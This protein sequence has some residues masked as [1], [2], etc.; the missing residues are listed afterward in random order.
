MSTPKIGH[1]RCFIP[2]SLQ[3][4]HNMPTSRTS[5]IT[6]KEW[7]VRKRRI[8]ELYVGDQLQLTGPDGV[9]ETMA[10]EGFTATK[11]Q[12]VYQFH[13]WQVRKNMKRHQWEEVIR[14]R[15]R[16]EAPTPI[17][18]GG[19]VLSEARTEKALRRY[20]HGMPQAEGSVS[21]NDGG[22]APGSTRSLT[23]TEDRRTAADNLV[24][25][26]EIP[27]AMSHHTTGNM[28]THLG[29]DFINSSQAGLMLEQANET[30]D[31]LLHENHNTVNFDMDIFNQPDFNFNTPV[32]LDDHFS[33]SQ[34][35][36]LGDDVLP[37]QG[38]FPG[39]L[40]GRTV[41]G[42][43]LRNHE[44][45]SPQL[46]ATIF[47]TYMEPTLD[48]YCSS[49]IVS[50]SPTTTC[51]LYRRFLKG[52]RWTPPSAAITAKL[53]KDIYKAARTSSS[54]G[55][56]LNMYHLVNNF[57]SDIKS[58]G[59]RHSP[60]SVT[61]AVK[62]LLSTETFFG[63]AFTFPEEVA[64]SVATEARLYS[65][66]ITSV[67]NG[68]TDLKGI[69]A[70]GVLKFLNRHQTTTISMISFLSSN[71]SPVAKSLAENILPIALE[72]DDVNTV[73][74]LL[75]HSGCVDANDAVSVY[76][77]E[78]YTPLQIAARSQSHSSVTL[79]VKLNVNVN[80]TPSGSPALDLLLRYRDQRSTI[81][82]VF[83]ESVNAL[84]R[85]GATIFRHYIAAELDNSVDKRLAIRLIEESG[86]QISKE[87][88]EDIHFLQKLT[89]GL[90]TPDARKAIKL[91]TEKCFGTGIGSLYRRIQ[92]ATMEHDERKLM[93]IL[94]PY[95]PSPS[96]I[97]QVPNGTGNT[98]L[99]NSAPHEQVHEAEYI[100]SVIARLVDLK[101]QRNLWHLKHGF[102]DELFAAV[103][104][105]NLQLAVRIM[106]L[107]SD[108][109]FIDRAGFIIYYAFYTAIKHGF[110]SIVRNFATIL[111]SSILLYDRLHENL[112][113]LYQIVEMRMPDLV[114]DM[115][116][117]GIGPN[118]M[119][120]PIGHD[121]EKSILKA[122]IKW[123][124][125][126][127]IRD[128]WQ[129]RSGVIYP[130]P[131]TM[132]LAAEKNQMRL[133]W[134]LFE[135][136]NI[137]H[138]ANMWPGAVKLAIQRED[139][140]LLD[141]MIARGASPSDDGLLEA[142]SSHP[143]MIEPFLERFLKVY[144]QGCAGYGRAAIRAAVIKYPESSRWI[145]MLFAFNLVSGVS[146]LG[147]E[148]G[149]TLLAVA[150]KMAGRP[151]IRLI[152]RL[153]DAGSDANV[154]M[155]N[156]TDTGQ[157]SRGKLDFLRDPL[158]CKG[159]KCLPI[160]TTPLL[161]SIVEGE[162]DIVRLLIERGADVNKAARFGIS[163]TPL[164]QAAEMNNLEIISLLLK[165]GADVN[166][167]TAIFTGATALQFAAIHGNCQMAS[168][169]LDHGAR[170]DVP[171]PKGP[172]GRWP[173]EAAAENGRLDMIQLLWDANN[174]PF[175]D[176]QCQMAM[177][178]AEHNGHFGCRDLIKELMAK[179]SGE[180]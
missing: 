64:I 34:A 128:L 21:C 20:A 139:L 73:S 56:E 111:T 156:F 19:I 138:P 163:H 142:V 54:N 18:L 153:L 148:D 125:T 79:L 104:G 76:R 2:R 106:E 113:L 55:T 41:G 123:G 137:A 98:E 168:L 29:T 68:F 4:E 178:L 63:E 161:L 1:I 51:Y 72:L 103:K 8:I 177:R 121:S 180:Y 130:S 16:G 117:A 66:L 88:I 122:A 23:S 42:V 77:G 78:R 49:L 43:R 53:I 118:P 9:I 94:M 102:A 33:P 173:L 108:C 38:D 17:V 84:L 22:T 74:F 149:I 35:D 97:V 100:E 172:Y 133:F 101:G 50:P 132:G 134:D 27:P 85:A 145:D 141:E 166:A 175:E 167:P 44:G 37:T 152:E 67:I 151:N 60:D 61:L 116:E 164:Q 58:V 31:M 12:Y 48:S 107:G 80:K 140:P 135:A 69:P 40:I 87:I 160:K 7:E 119:E 174:G 147:D 176:K 95:V 171:P 136:W 146:L 6:Q 179:S 28:A 105:R 25:L 45:L 81:S 144:P 109:Y 62:G 39:Q 162:E 32:A 24:Y 120:S 90:N 57:M 75:H 154:T 131:C 65:R 159:R 92:H 165:N 114:R 129:A 89:G 157:T 112:Q 143:S 30:I 126:S 14:E 124:D 169:L 99:I 26:T 170:F 5:R 155:A 96:T 36:C 115:I 3:S 110:Y 13:T 71:S 11:A 158:D 83:L 46:A 127:I 47:D 150:I 91:M 52:N 82:D 59:Q 86:P 70:P 15:E 93:D 10:K